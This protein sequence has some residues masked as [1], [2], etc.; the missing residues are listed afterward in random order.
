MTIRA[1]D[2]LWRFDIN[3]RKYDGHGFS[4]RII[5]AEHFT[6]HTITGETTRSWL[7]DDAFGH[8]TKVSK[9]ELRE[10]GR[11]GF[12]GYQ[13]FTDQGREDD[14]WLHEHRHKIIRMIDT[15]DG[16]TLRKVAEVIGYTA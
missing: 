4:A 6:P 1:G 11:N 14:I 13:W 16:T 5:Y 7:I 10:A 2:R 9:S 15:A 12:G 8:S 3:R